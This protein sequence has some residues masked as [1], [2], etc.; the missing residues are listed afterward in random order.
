LAII[1]LDVELQIFLD[2]GAM[3]VDA[4]GTDFE[5]LSEQD[6]MVAER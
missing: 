2:L 5:N 4:T 6:L 3:Y 1:V